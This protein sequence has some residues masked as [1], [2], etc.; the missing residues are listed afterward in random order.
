MGKL[1]NGGGSHNLF[2]QDVW[3]VRGNKKL[4]QNFSRK[5]NGKRPLRKPRRRWSVKSKICL[6]QI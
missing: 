6:Q 2:G 5:L 1:Y 4:V 3:H